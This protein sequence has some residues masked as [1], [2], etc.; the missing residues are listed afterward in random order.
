MKKKGSEA[1]VPKL[2]GWHP[3]A[4]QVT[5]LM[6]QN[7]FAQLV[8]MLSVTSFPSPSSW[9]F[10]MSLEERVCILPTLGTTD[11]Q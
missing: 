11:L 2:L 5:S 6:L 9:V 4:F 3:V 10:S 8:L 7:V 1:V